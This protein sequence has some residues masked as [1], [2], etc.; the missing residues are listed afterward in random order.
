M[1]QCTKCKRWLDLS[2][3][4]S[5]TSKKTGR[6]TIQSYCNECKQ[7][8]IDAWKSR[9]R[10]K[11][12]EYGRRHDEKN[13]YKDSQQARD[14][15]QATAERRNLR[16]HN[17][18]VTLVPKVIAQIRKEIMV[19]DGVKQCF[20]CKRV[21]P[22]EMHTDKS[23]CKECTAKESTKQRRL[24]P[25]RHKTNRNR[26]YKA[27]A[28]DPQRRMV[29]RIRQSIQKGISR[30]GKGVSVHGGKMRYV[31]CTG[32]EAASYIEQQFTAGM[33]WE[34]YGRWHIDHVKPLAT[35]D[36]SREDQRRLAFHYTNIQPMWAVENMRKNKRVLKA[37]HQPELILGPPM[38][39]SPSVS[40]AHLLLRQ[41]D[42]L[43][44]DEMRYT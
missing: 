21:L 27:M 6:V 14:A 7:I 25:E 29:W 15:R 44:T 42:K 4:R 10:H 9:N 18:D 19:R 30:Y 22:L 38:V 39:P 23:W 11:Q 32:K 33:T 8:Q 35:F 3:F 12:R 40:P 37:V 36:L 13:P 34:N 5:W 26:H 28:S 43:L 24:H 17:E 31:G 41:R 1:R 16:E 20:R 2:Q